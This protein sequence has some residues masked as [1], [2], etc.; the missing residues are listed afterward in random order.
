MITYK[1]TGKN[2]QSLNKM[3]KKNQKK[4]KTNANNRILKYVLCQWEEMIHIKIN[5]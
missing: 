4:K 2:I 1:K 5:L 3:L